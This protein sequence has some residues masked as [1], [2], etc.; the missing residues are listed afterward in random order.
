MAGKV[1]RRR[2]DQR[3]TSFSVWAVTGVRLLGAGVLPS[4]RVHDRQGLVQ[5]TREPPVVERSGHNDYLDALE[6]SVAAVRRLLNTVGL[7]S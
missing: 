2:T 3:V 5:P 7:E 1:V 4:L 6:V